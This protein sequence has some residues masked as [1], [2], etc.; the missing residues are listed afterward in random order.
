MTGARSWIGAAVGLVLLASGADAGAADHKYVG[1]K[2]C[3]ACHKKELIGDQHGE[4]AK[5]PHAKAFE[6]LKGEKA[7]KLAKEKGGSGPPDESDKCLKCHVPGYGLPASAF[8]KPVKAADGVQCESCH[9]PGKDYRKKLV[10]SDHD[11]AVAK[12]MW[13]PEKDEKICTTCHNDES[14]SWDPAKGF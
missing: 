12:G 8:A 1:L 14:P 11:K 4:W 13:E 5:G 3:K 9:G 2:S 6:T 10:M 7:A